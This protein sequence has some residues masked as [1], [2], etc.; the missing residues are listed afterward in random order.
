MRAAYFMYTRHR[1]E[2]VTTMRDAPAELNKPAPASSALGHQPSA[3]IAR[4]ANVKP[5]FR[6]PFASGWSGFFVGSV[7][8]SGLTP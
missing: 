6:V 8:Q 3:G 7:G 2:L 5:R 4:L 1:R